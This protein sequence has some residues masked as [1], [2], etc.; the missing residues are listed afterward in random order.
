MSGFG[1]CVMVHRKTGKAKEKRV[2][3]IGETLNIFVVLVYMV[4]I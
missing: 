3:G 4:K 2:P 1:L